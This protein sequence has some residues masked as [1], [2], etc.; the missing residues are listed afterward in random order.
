MRILRLNLTDW[1]NYRTAEIEFVPGPNVLAGSNGQ[2]KTNLVE[3]IGYLTT[4]SS[5]RVGGD[6]ALIRAGEDSAV[7]RAVVVAGDREVLAEVL[8]NRSA[9]NRAQ[10]NRSAVRPREITRNVSSVLFAP[11]DLALVRGEPAARRR[12]LDEL[13]VQ[14]TPRLAGVVADY[15]RAL[16]QRNGLLRTARAGGD[17]G[18][19]D[20]WDE[21]LIATGTELLDARTELAAELEPYV[22]EQYAVLAGEDQRVTLEPLRS[23]DAD[24]AGEGSTAERF[25]AALAVA[26]RREL[27]RGITLVGPH[28][29]DL[30]L[31]VNGLPARS[32]ASHGESWSVALA[33]RLGSVELLRRALPTGDPIVILDDVFAELD[34]KRRT[35]LAGQVGRYEQV[36]I[37]AAVEGD[38]PGALAGRVT[39]I[40]AGE[41][42]GE[43]PA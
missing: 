3:A 27:E 41:I 8:L 37:T 18:T 25:A 30:V 1:R 40:R 32:H 12:F 42:V 15:D 14:R 38:I 23:I 20:V 11:E 39:H 17:F 22:A 29:D 24:G 7:I 9:P 35:R 2:G 43:V 4:L 36:L 21:R 26:R 33:L 5:H 19:L 31:G 34:E 10:V 13:L 16:K 28:R 6:A